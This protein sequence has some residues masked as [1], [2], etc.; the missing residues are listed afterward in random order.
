VQIVSRYPHK[1]DLVHT[2]GLFKGPLATLFKGCTQVSQCDLR[3]ST[4][5]TL[6]SPC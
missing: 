4:G 2:Q 5:L 1:I 3:P 6:T